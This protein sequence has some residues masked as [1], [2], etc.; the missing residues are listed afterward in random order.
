MLP[1]LGHIPTVVFVHETSAAALKMQKVPSSAMAGE[2]GS[3]D[4]LSWV[5]ASISFLLSGE[6]PDASLGEETWYLPA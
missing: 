3:S 5:S 4:L 1:T 2:E 6:S